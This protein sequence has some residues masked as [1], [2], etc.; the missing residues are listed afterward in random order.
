MLTIRY[1]HDAFAERIYI[2][3]ATTHSI[4]MICFIYSRDRDWFASAATC[5][6]VRWDTSTYVDIPIYECM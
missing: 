6:F 3:I 1:G 4:V 2:A 5:I